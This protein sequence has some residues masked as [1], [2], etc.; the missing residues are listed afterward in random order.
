MHRNRVTS[1][2]SPPVIALSFVPVLTIGNAFRTVCFNSAP[3]NH[4]MVCIYTGRY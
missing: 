3:T 4:A 1:A 2:Q